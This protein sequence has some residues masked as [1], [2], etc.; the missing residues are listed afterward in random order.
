MPLCAVKP[1]Y[2]LPTSNPKAS[3]PE[4]VQASIL[5]CSTGPMKGGRGVRG[6]QGRGAM[7]GRSTMLQRG[8][9]WEREKV[10]SMMPVVMVSVRAVKEVEEE[11]VEE[12]EEG[13]LGSVHF[14]VSAA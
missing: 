3:N 1:L 9:E 10:E 4:Y 12:E 13:C 7:R 14:L 5:R 2:D 11:E 6:R 8:K